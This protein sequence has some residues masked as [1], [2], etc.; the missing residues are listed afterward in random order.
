MP[1]YEYECL[2]CS[3]RFDKLIMDK[4]DERE[5][6]CPKCNSANVERRFSRFSTTSSDES[7]FAND[8]S[9]RKEKELEKAEQKWVGPEYLDQYFN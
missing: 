9:A 1:V 7:R 5:L 6:S 8:P 2:D 3:K 4:E